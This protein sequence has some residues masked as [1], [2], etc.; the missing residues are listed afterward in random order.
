MG[1]RWNFGTVLISAKRI[2]VEWL[3][4]MRLLIS[5]IGLLGV[6]NSNFLVEDLKLLSNVMWKYQ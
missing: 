4:T 5:G 3:I 2:S 1:G 6:Q